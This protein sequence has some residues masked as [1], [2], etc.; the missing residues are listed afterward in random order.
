MRK[1]FHAEPGLATNNL[2]R[3]VPK[4]KG[5]NLTIP[6]LMIPFNP[7]GY[8]MK[9]SQADCE[10][11]LASMPSVVIADK[12]DTAAE[13]QRETWDYLCRHNIGSANIEFW[14]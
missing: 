9:P 5:W 8:L 7:E 3:L 12:V 1:R 2:G 10:A 11:L 6:F 13:P 14:G 4:L